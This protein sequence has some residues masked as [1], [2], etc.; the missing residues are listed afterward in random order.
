MFSK[1]WFIKIIILF[2]DKILII[3]I[4]FCSD[5]LSKEDVASSNISMSE[6]LKRALAIHTNCV[7]PPL[8]VNPPSPIM[9]SIP[10]G[11]DSKKFIPSIF[12]KQS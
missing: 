1:L 12:F 5:F 4:I 2:L 11:N 8:I 9:V 7:C 6:S 10:F 3:S